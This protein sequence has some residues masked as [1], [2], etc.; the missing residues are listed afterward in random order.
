MGCWSFAESLFYV[1]CFLQSSHIPAKNKGSRKEVLYKFKLLLIILVFG[2][3]AQPVTMSWQF[4][5]FYSKIRSKVSEFVSPAIDDSQRRHFITQFSENKCGAMI[6]NIIVV[7]L[8]LPFSHLLF[9]PV[10]A[11]LSRKI[12]M[13][14]RC[15]W[16]TP[17]IPCTWEAEI[18]RITVSGQP[19]QIVHKI[20][21]SK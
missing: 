11:K 7:L 10:L 6:Y 8:P 13:Y 2:T 18:R 15:W 12:C 19:G 4:T 16:L 20:P 5:K 14:V 1:V 9:V 3:H 17:V 21:P